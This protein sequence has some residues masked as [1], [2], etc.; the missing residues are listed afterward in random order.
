MLQIAV[1]SDDHV[2]LGVIESGGE[3]RGLA[4]IAPQPDACHTRVERG[5]LPENRRRA[6]CA[7]VI[8]EDQFIV[9][10]ETFHHFRQTAIKNG[11][12]LFFVMKRDDDGVRT[13][14]F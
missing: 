1:H 9:F 8:D 12:I 7:A 10:A 6:I 4:E 5:D 2:A 3:R 13:F 11:Q 14:H